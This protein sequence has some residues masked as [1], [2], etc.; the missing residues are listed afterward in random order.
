MSNNTFWLL[1]LQESKTCCLKELLLSKHNA[2]ATAVQDIINNND[3]GDS[4]FVLVGRQ[5]DV[6]KEVVECI[7]LDVSLTEEVRNFVL[8]HSWKEKEILFIHF[9][10]LEM[11]RKVAIQ[12]IEVLWES[13]EPLNELQL[14][15]FHSDVNLRL[16][17]LFDELPD[18]DENNLSLSLYVN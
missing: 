16:Q 14:N 8:E 5:I 11:K 6:Y 9:R 17:S 12:N 3:P 1:L 18:I 10:L 13:H 2:M 15:R 4:A 7:S